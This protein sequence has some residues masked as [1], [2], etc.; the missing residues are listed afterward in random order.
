[1]EKEI[2]FCFEKLQHNEKLQNTEEQF[3]LSKGILK[4]SKWHS[5]YFKT[6]FRKLENP[7]ETV[8]ING[9]KVVPDEVVEVKLPS[10][11][12]RLLGLK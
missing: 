3:W 6:K 8:T 7:M 1:M 10:P 5:V 4:T 12:L 9:I 2:T 11:A